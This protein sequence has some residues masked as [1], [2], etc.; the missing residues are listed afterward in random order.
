MIGTL[1]SRRTDRRRLERR[2]RGL[3]SSVL[4]LQIA[5]AAGL[6]PRRAIEV[7]GGLPIDRGALGTASDDFAAIGARLGLGADLSSA[8]LRLEP[9]KSSTGFV[10]VLDVLR[11]A[12]LDGVE[13]ALHLELLVR[14]LRRERA[15][16]LDAAAQRLTVSLLFPLVLCILPAF[17]LLAVVPL[18][19][20]ALTSLPG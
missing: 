14:D 9:E 15:V 4:L 10:R 17:V 2:V 5:T 6:G 3:P 13:L 8:I 16:S 18:L 7:V 12:E 19:V 11:R 20:G 1:T